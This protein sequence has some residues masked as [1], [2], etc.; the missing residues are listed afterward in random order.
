M[1]RDEPSESNNI[2][3]K[4]REIRRT[5]GLTTSELADRSGFT[6]GYISQ[7]ERGLTNPSVGALYRICDTLGISVGD[8]FLNG[9]EQS[10]DTSCSPV[11]SKV[12]R[13]DCRLTFIPPGTS[14]QHQMLCPDF[15]HSMELCWSYIPAGENNGELPVTHTGEECIVV[16]QGALEVYVG[17]ETYALERG[18]AIYFDASVPHGWRNLTDQEVQI[19]WAASPPHF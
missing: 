15:Q 17:D 12:V 9:V 11:I 8:L 6:S 18:D 4:I 14:V 3:R 10:P 1:S 5:K 16:I 7:V 19:I 2:G 13:R